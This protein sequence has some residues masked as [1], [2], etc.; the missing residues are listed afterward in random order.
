M[1]AFN[2]IRQFG[3]AIFSKMG[4]TEIKYIQSYLTKQ[5]QFLFFA[6]DRPTQTHCVRV[7]RTCQKLIQKDLMVNKN[8][9]IRSALLHDIGKTANAITTFHRVAIVLLSL[10]SPK[11]FER[12]ACQ[13]RTRGRLG[14]ALW[15]HIN[16]P[17]K[18]AQLAEA[19]NLPPELVY[20][21]K[22][23]HQP[24]TSEEPLELTLLRRADQL[25]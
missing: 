9:L 24:Y 4:A 11:L 3:H 15:A 14:K 7:A 25:N 22:N 1:I 5:E 13:P 21:I 8:L 2:R 20:L 23:H 6:M 16:H 10:L 19:A 12:I 18:G 17:V